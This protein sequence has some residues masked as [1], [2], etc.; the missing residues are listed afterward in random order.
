MLCKRQ[1]RSVNR[2]K[3][4]SGSFSGFFGTRTSR[5]VGKSFR[6][7]AITSR[8][9][10]RLQKAFPGYIPARRRCNDGQNGHVPGLEEE[11]AAETFAS[12]GGRDRERVLSEVREVETTSEAV[13][14]KISLCVMDKSAGERPDPSL[15]SL[16]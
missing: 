15:S 9:G 6:T 7:K 8:T 16:R 10:L 5:I 11:K 3:K 4:S 2:E 13:G 1:K 12:R 14:D